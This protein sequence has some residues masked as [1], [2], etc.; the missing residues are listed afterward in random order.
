MYLGATFLFV[1]APL[2]MG[3]FFGLVLG[4]LLTILLAVRSV[5][6]EKMLVDELEGYEDYRKKVKYR[7]IP[8]VW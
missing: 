5:G 1:G 3:S 8:F 6:E 7:L 4:I 2:L